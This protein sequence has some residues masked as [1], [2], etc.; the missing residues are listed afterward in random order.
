MARTEGTCWEGRTWISCDPTSIGS[1]PRK[2]FKLL[3][4]NILSDYKTSFLHY[5][6][7]KNWDV[8]CRSLL[9]E[10]KTYD[11]DIICLQDVD[12][13]QDW[14]RPQL[15]LLGY[16]TIYKQRTQTKNFHYEG[17]LIAFRREV[18]QMFKSQPF[19]LNGAV[20]NDDRGRAFRERSKTDDVGV[21]VFLQP[22]SRETINSAVCVCCSM[23]SD[24]VN[25]NDIRMV[26]TTYIA[27]QVEVANMEFHVPVIM[28][29]SMYDIPSSLAYTVMCTGRIPLAGQVPKTCRPPYGSATCRGS[30]LLK[31]LPPASSLADFPILSYRIS[32]RPGGSQVLAFREQIDVGVG[33]CVKYAEQ[34]DEKGN[35]RMVAQA[36]LE[37][38]IAGL[39]SDVPYEFRV[40]AVNEVGQGVWSDISAPIVMNNPDRVS[41]S[42]LYNIL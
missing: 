34:T 22:W 2:S 42:C 12:H 18:F 27:H 3:S 23:L 35:I 40:V 19:E 39:V 26:Q 14:W 21:I 33:D 10:I 11:M 24:E 7:T 6:N 16:D 41:I 37:Y 38:T 1:A 30:L 17:V 36:E 20:L 31:W 28:A 9:D 32:W 5:T 29:C 13:Y 15:T 4:Y 8:R 25:N